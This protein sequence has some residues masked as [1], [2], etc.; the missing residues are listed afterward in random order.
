MAKYTKG[1]KNEDYWR[2]RAEELLTESFRNA[3]TVERYINGK[4]LKALRDTTK[5]YNDMM[6]PFVVEGVLDANKLNQARLFNLAFS[7]KY[8]RLEKQIELFCHEVSQLEQERILK[9]LERTYKNVYVKT[10]ETF[11]GTSPGL[12]LLNK[13]AV[14]IAVKTP[15]TKDGREFSDRIW[16]NRDALQANLR[17]DISE[18][19]LRGESLDKTARKLNK[20]FSSGASNCNRIVRTETNAIYSKAA[21]KSYTDAGANKVEILA[22]LDKR[23]SKICEEKNGTIVEVATARIGVELPPFH[24]NCRTTFVAVIE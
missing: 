12:E 21:K 23:T 11:K 10:Y 9:H 8:R 14:K 2:A 22:A 16:A 19:V 7:E 6:E 5:A 4:Y 13:E 24:P 3:E 18:G 15:W 1:M 17:R 20:T